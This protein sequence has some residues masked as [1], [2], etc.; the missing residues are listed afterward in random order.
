MYVLQYVCNIRIDMKCKYEPLK[1]F[2][3][4]SNICKH[5]QG[6]CAHRAMDGSGNAEEKLCME[7]FSALPNTNERLNASVRVS[8]NIY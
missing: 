5:I 6:S 2:R 4:M 3:L 8:M 1:T 7:T